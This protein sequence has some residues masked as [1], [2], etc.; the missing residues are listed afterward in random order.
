[1][2]HAYLPTSSLNRQKCW[3][4]AAQSEFRPNDS[5]P[6]SVTSGLSIKQQV[7][8]WIT[9]WASSLANASTDESESEELGADTRQ[10]VSIF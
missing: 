4:K 8:Q 2:D 7:T 1:M 10:L 3:W 6:D 9:L 5:T